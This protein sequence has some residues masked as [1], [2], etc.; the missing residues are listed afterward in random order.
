MRIRTKT[1]LVFVGVVAPLVC[2]VYAISQII[3]LRHFSQIEVA[4]ARRTI[5]Q[6]ENV[7]KA[8]VEDLSVRVADWA[9]WDETYRFLQDANQSFVVQNLNS[10]SFVYGLNV[11]FAVFLDT[12]RRVVRVA[13]FDLESGEP[14]DPPAEFL[15]SL[16]PENPL[17][18]ARP[19]DSPAAGFA[20]LDA[21]LL[22]VSGLPVLKSDF[23]GP[24]TG[25]LVFAVL[26]DSRYVRS[27]GD[28]LGHTIEVLAPGA[29]INQGEYDALFAEFKA[30]NAPPVSVLDDRQIAAYS[31]LT[32]VHG[33][34]GSILRVSV[35]RDTYP[36]GVRALNLL[37][38]ALILVGVS[39]SV[40]S[41]LLWDRF[42][43]A[44]IARLSA[45]IAAISQRRNT[46]QRVTVSGN[47]EITSFETM[48]NE[49]LE[50]VHSAESA[51][52]END[53]RLR[54]I[55]YTAVDGI[56][57]I[58]GTGAIQSLN[59][60]AEVT[61]GYAPN[62]VI[63]RRFDILVPDIDPEPHTN[64]PAM[65]MQEYLGSGR[66][67]VGRRKNGESFPLYLAV[68][69]VP[70]KNMHIYSA[71]M[72][73][74]TVAKRNEAKLTELAT[75][76]SLTGLNNRRYFLERL[77][78]AVESKKRFGHAMC[79]AYLD[80]DEFKQVNDHFGHAVGDDV[81]AALGKIIQAEVRKIDI[82]GRLGG[83]EF[84]IVFIQTTAKA[85]L[86]SVDRIRKAIE[87]VS[88]GHDAARPV[89]VTIT[90]GLADMPQGEC[91]AKSLLEAADSALYKAKEL[92]KNRCGV[93][94]EQS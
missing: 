45:E 57:T 50:T 27:L 13:G 59:R 68:S 20:F 92:G 16:T 77:E 1:G 71:I 63:G 65:N 24:P 40:A 33:N 8:R 43:L 30:N 2:A 86:L 42:V 38:F 7:L 31:F 14:M 25:Y 80:V 83:D 88:F 60:S 78:F 85:A 72:R 5:V 62:E 53:A 52:M 79:A 28:M 12:E 69:E 76:D 15:H 93:F 61:F 84:C 67:V 94:N 55:L 73:D 58:D 22:M 11:N 17:L 23:T 87:A 46:A 91:S 9:N 74:I 51:L 90:A 19:S 35:P 4:D 18:T 56:V 6:V 70:L 41:M 39:V 34:P 64:Q 81:L 75:I 54:A 29:G 32:D 66:E 47:D 44:R 89:R 3:L 21:G 82:A 37:M 49:M 10:E 36:Q 26:M 48:I